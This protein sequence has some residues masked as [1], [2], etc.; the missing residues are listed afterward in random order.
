MGYRIRRVNPAGVQDNRLGI[1]PRYYP[2]DISYKY[3]QGIGQWL[4][5][6]MLTTRSI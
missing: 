4:P 6:N 3:P 2:H 5:K 1:H